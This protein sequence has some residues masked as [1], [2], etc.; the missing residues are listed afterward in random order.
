MIAVDSS[1]IIDVIYNDPEFAEASGVALSEA[2][3]M[4]DVVMCDAALA[5]V[6][7]VAV[8]EICNLFT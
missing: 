7:F 1:I 8:K 4:G 5:D 2:A 3:D 6:D